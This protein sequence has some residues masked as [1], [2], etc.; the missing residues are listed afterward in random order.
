MELKIN[1]KCD[2]CNEQTAIVLPYGPHNL[3]KKHFIELFEKRIKKTTA[4]EGM[5][6]YGEKIAVG[7]SGGKDSMV[8]LHMLNELFGKTKHN[9]IIAIMIDEGIKGYRDK[10]IEIAKKYCEENNIEH[11]IIKFE[12]EI[13]I[14]MHKTMEKIKKD[15]SLGST[16]SF[17]GVFR[18]K[19][20]N[21]KA[22]EIGADKLATGHNLDDEVQS[23][24]MSITD[25]DLTRIARSGETTGQ[26]KNQKLVPRIKPLYETPEK[27]II[28]YAN[29]KG[30]EYYRQE[31][32]PY[33]WMAKRNYYRQMLNELENNFPGTKF[34]ILEAHKQLKPLLKKMEMEKGANFKECTI[35]GEPC[36]GEICGTCKQLKKLNKTKNQ[37][38][39]KTTETKKETLSC[40]QTKFSN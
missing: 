34:K 26:R 11:E 21:E 32:C 36:N 35:C 16:C 5:L 12:K 17:C 31:C 25:N 8:T 9:K 33:S 23:I 13:G 24:I 10:A 2:R 22:A 20:L 28:A 19:I 4:K 14:D 29:M 3:C 39:Y 27:E 18:R 37:K 38:I 7:V 15:K 1:N 6:K 30:I 40:C